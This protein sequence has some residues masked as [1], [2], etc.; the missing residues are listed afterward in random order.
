M[1]YITKQ[2]LLDELGED[3]LIQLTDDDNIG[4]IGE[5]RVEKA[6]GYAVGTVD[7][8]AR[9][10]YTIP[11]PTTPLVKS[12]C[13][14]LA[15]FHLWKSRATNSE[16]GPYKVRKDAHDSAIKR[17]CDIQSGK[18][19]LDVPSLEETVINPGSPDRVLRGS[20]E[21]PTVFNDTN[22]SSY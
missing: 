18:A 9:S 10:R 15:V 2:D 5:K 22:L 20:E 8:Y 17:L 13:L 4:E 7:T 19:A 21:T 14:D 1:S 3:K 12:L 16:D 6:L 11:V